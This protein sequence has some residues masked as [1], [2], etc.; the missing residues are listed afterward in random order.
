MRVLV[1]LLNGQ[2]AIEKA[3]PELKDLTFLTSV[4]LVKNELSLKSLKITA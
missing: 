4:F 1:N 2:A 3:G